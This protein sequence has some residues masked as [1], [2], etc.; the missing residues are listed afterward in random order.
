MNCIRK[1]SIRMFKVQGNKRF[2]DVEVKIPERPDRMTDV[3]RTQNVFQV[4][5]QKYINKTD[6]LLF[7]PIG[8]R[9]FHLC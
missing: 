8:Y 7:L 4:Q 9:K 6:P 1:S 2:S 3:N 5:F